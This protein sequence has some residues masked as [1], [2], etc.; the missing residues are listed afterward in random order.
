MMTNEKENKKLLIFTP[1]FSSRLK[2]IFDF[3]LNQELGLEFEFCS[4]RMF[5]E[6]SKLNKFSYSNENYFTN[7]PFIKSHALLKSI[8][9]H[10]VI[11]DFFT[12]QN[13]KAFFK[14]NSTS[15]FAFDIF[16]ASFY[17]ISRYEEYLPFLKD[18]HGRFQ[19]EQSLAFKEG[20]LEIPLVNIWINLFKTNLL[21][22][23]PSLVFKQKQFRFISTIDIDNAF[24]DL[25]KG[26][27]RTFLSSLKMLITLKI[28]YF[29]E[30][31]QVLNHQLNDK[32]DNYNYLNQIHKKYGLEP[33]YFILFSKYGKYD[34]NLSTNNSAFQ[35]LLNRLAESNE[36]G[37]HPSYQ[38]N[39]SLKILKR[40]KTNLE[41]TISKSVTK[42][43]QHFIKLKFPDTYENLEPLGIMQ[44]FSMGYSTMPGFRA[45][46]CSP[47]KFFNLKTNQE[48]NLEIIPFALMDAGFIHYQKLNPE[49]TF[50]KIKKIIESVKKVDGLFVSL[51]HNETLFPTNGKY[52]WR[53]VFEQMLR[54]VKNGNSI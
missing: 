48:T 14:T 50:E 9:I 18:K 36:I 32:Y 2:Y 1:Q 35:S 31:I 15:F 42:S 54:E 19:A 13:H 53:D 10:P 38:S 47:F 20:F 33:I 5:F 25:N 3:I 12:Y 8:E 21:K 34:K 24:A 16:A 45:S 28:R 43:R 49:E 44:D 22:E 41:K 6:N 51:W 37:L 46:V 27:F 39:K 4:D 7:L 23:F 52:S 30:K 40:E 11:F 29:I 26:V 17:L